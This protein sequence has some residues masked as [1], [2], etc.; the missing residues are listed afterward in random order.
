MKILIVLV[1]LF[2]I[3]WG[4]NIFKDLKLA[5]NECDAGP[6]GANE[7]KFPMDLQK[8]AATISCVM[9]KSGLVTENGD[10]VA[11]NIKKLFGT[12]KDDNEIDAMIQKCTKKGNTTE[13]AAVNMFMCLQEINS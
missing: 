1:I 9:M 7:V 2:G 11:S 13:E 3:A 12:V 10:P 5:V 6:G 4:D 8:A